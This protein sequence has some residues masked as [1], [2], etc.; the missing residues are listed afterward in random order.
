MH[1]S[2]LIS[3]IFFFSGCYNMFMNSYPEAIILFINSL[4]LIFLYLY[5]YYNNKKY[6][7]LISW[8]ETNKEKIISDNCEL[9]W[10]DHNINKDTILTQYNYCYSAIIISFKQSTEFVFENSS[11][12]KQ[13]KFISLLISFL[14]GW[15]GIPWGPIYTYGAISSTFR[16]GTS[17]SVHKLIDELED[18]EKIE[19]DKF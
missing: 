16:G 8:L 2:L 15:W 13:V 9:V 17:L 10:N 4:T 11:K 3:T 14:F 19:K 5:N 7:D 18:V 6:N 1:I 12:Q